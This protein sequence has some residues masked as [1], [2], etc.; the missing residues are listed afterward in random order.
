MKKVLISTLL[1]IS[2][3]APFSSY[4]AL[5]ATNVDRGR[6]WIEVGGWCSHSNWSK[7]DI[8]DEH[9][10]IV[11]FDTKMPHMGVSGYVPCMTG[12]QLVNPFM[13]LVGDPYVA[14]DSGKVIELSED[15]PTCHNYAECKAS[16]KF[17]A[18]ATFN[19]SGQMAILPQIPTDG[20]I[21][22]IGEVSYTAFDAFLPYILIAGGIPLV[23]YVVKK[24]LDLIKIKK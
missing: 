1:I 15:I 10:S 12:Q 22:S 4:A 3:F 19:V 23:F 21:A 14:G 7:Y 8:F 6:M 24:L 9:K 11:F 2:A 18:E 17:I 20:V 16:E 5:Y 13:G